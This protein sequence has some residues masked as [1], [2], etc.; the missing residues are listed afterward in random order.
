MLPNKPLMPGFIRP[1]AP[2]LR[3]VPPSGPEWVH[4]VKWDGWRLQAHKWFGDV[5]LFTQRERDASETFPLIADAISKIKA[6]SL[7]L[8][9]EVIATNADGKPDFHQLRRRRPTALYVVFDLLF[10]DGVDLRQRPWTERRRQLERLMSR[11]KVEAYIFPRFGMMGPGYCVPPASR[12]S[13]ASSASCDPRS[14]DRARRMPGSR[15]RCRGG[16]RPIEDG[17]LE[18]SV[19]TERLEPGQYHENLLP[20]VRHQPA[21]RAA[22]NREQSIVLSQPPFAGFKPRICFIPNKSAAAK[23]RRHD[24]DLAADRYRRYCALTDPIPPCPIC[25]V[26]DNEEASLTMLGPHANGRLYMRCR[27]GSQNFEIT[28]DI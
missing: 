22:S 10:L 18:L 24:L 15:R 4:E 25:Y 7:I 23:L 2:V 6:R 14:T 27:S 26:R 5:R 21:V 12:P 20:V 1:C 8:D 16:R 11:N 13:R 19:P 17:L 9:G 28:P 3:R